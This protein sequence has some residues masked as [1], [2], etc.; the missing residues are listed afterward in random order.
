[1]AVRIGKPWQ[2]GRGRGIGD[3]V[4]TVEPEAVA[5]LIKRSK[6][7]LFV[8]GS[9]VL[10]RE[11][12]GKKA[13][14]YA[15]EMARTS[16]VPVVAT[17]HTVKGFLDRGFKPDAWMPVVNVVD[18]LRDPEWNGVKGEGQHDLVVFFGVTC[19]LGEQGLSTLKHFAPHMR[20]IAICPSYHP[21]AYMSLIADGEKLTKLIETLKE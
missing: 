7:P 18:R 17:G 8:F 10:E 11:F 2:I 14:D 6:R 13:I 1:L 3:T 21:S 16:G 15:I 12:D 20:T 4:L 5:K 9:K 19:V